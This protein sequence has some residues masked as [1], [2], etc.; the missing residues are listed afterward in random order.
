MTG[1]SLSSFQDILSLISE[2]GPITEGIFIISPDSTL[3][4]TLMG[5]LD[6]GEVVDMKGQSVH[7]LAWLLK[8]GTSLPH[9]TS[10]FF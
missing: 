4:K 5:K 6:S 10:G 3:C 8:V 1:I 7:V 9:S 2:K